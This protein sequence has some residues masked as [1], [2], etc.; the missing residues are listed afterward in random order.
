M[1]RRLVWVLVLVIAGVV[2]GGRAIRSRTARVAV[3][4]AAD[5][6]RAS[7]DTIRFERTPFESALLELARHTRLRLA[8]RWDLLRQAG[9]DP[10]TPITLQIPRGSA[11]AALGDLIDA[12]AQGRA[13]LEFFLDE[14]GAIVI[15]TTADYHDRALVSRSYDVGSLLPTGGDRRAAQDVV[16]D[17]VRRQIDN[18][19]HAPSAGGDVSAQ[20]I[21]GRLVVVADRETQWLVEPFLR[22]RNAAQVRTTARLAGLTLAGSRSWSDRP[23]SPLLQEL[24]CEFGVRIAPNWAMLENRVEPDTPMTLRVRN[25]NA[26]R[27]LSIC[28]QSSLLRS[29]TP[30]G[31]TVD[32]AGTVIVTTRHQIDRGNCVVRMYDLYPITRRWPDD[33]WKRREL[34]RAVAL[35]I[36]GERD[37]EFWRSPTGDAWVRADGWRFYVRQTPDNHRQIS[38]LVEQVFKAHHLPG[39]RG[40][41]QVPD[42]ANFI[43]ARHPD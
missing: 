18:R 14:R 11:R 38:R 5:G 24:A 27:L 34:T 31:W 15:T 39:F 40:S 32:A 20:V 2:I 1:R 4:E 13:Q 36:E 22:G 19:P 43:P 35:L 25:I 26:G 17:M 37:A 29:Q 30:V 33:P 28:L 23:L 9:V 12:A 6:L 41:E 16:A 10:T 42:D 7:V 3:N 8:P 21:A